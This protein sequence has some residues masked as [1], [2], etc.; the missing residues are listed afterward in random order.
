MNN[1]EK[2]IGQTSYSKYGSIMVI[3][4]YINCNNCTI[5]FPQY[6]WETNRSYKAFINGNI[7]CPYEKSVYNVGYKGEGP[8]DSSEKYIDIYRHWQKII[9]RCYDSKELERVPAYIDCSV[10]DYWHCYQNYAYWHIEN[11]YEIPGQI[12]ELD[13]DILFKGNKEYSPDTCCFVPHDINCLL[14]KSNKARGKYPI[15]VSKR[16]NRYYAQINKNG[17]RTHI[18]SYLTPEEA[19][20]AYKEAKENQIK[21]IADKYIDYLP[22]NVYN[23]LYAY[24]VEIDD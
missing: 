9:K 11:Y 10:N 5:L 13:K 6:N 24:E 1:K 23:A 8:F 22:N 3:I 16:K 19:F 17:K 12:M 21:E 15:G 2:F 14:L 4:D 18:G 20:F 7:I